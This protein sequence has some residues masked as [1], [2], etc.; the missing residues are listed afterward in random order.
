MIALAV[1][2]LAQGA[3]PSPAPL[4]GGRPAEEIFQERCIACHGADGTGQTRKGREL[5]AKDFTRRRWQKHTTDE[6][7][8]AAI[9]DG[10]PRKKMPAFKDKLSPEEIRSLVPYLRSFGKEVKGAH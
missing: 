5:K 4:A 6:E 10:I 3:T 7:I 2:L 9:T 8:V 1:A